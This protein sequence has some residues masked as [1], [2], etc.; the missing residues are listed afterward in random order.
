LG[1]SYTLALALLVDSHLWDTLLQN[2][3]RSTSV[4]A[5]GF[6]IAALAVNASTR[7]DSDYESCA[8]PER[9]G[10]VLEQTESVRS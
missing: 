7:T 6:F 5:G 2:L 8:C 3:S 4:K 10:G 9:L 1:A